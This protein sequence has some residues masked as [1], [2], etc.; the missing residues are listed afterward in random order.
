MDSNLVTGRIM[1]IFFT[2]DT[3]FNHERT[4]TVS[5]SARPF[6]CVKEMNQTIIERW[7]TVVNDGD[8]V[9]HLGDLCLL[10]Q[11]DI[12][13]QQLKGRKI[14]IQGNH[15]TKERLRN[16]IGWEEVHNY[17]EI[18][19]EKTRLFLCHYA[20]RTWHHSHKGTLHLYGHSHGNLPGDSQSLDVG[21]DCWGF[22]P[23][24]LEEI[25]ER[26]KTFTKRIEIDH[27]QPDSD[28]GNY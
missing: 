24:T 1:T 15:D 22:S 9:Y 25:K 19:V 5:N 26:L 4:L 13:L 8:L 28:N 12:W 21:V 23:I 14:L 11:M 6:S 27:H 17:L 20:M 2:S 18:K 16:A 3:H 7:N 10:S